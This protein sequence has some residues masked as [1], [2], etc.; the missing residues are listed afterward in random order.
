MSAASPR[1]RRRA[2]WLPASL[3]RARRLNTGT[4]ASRGQDE[5]EQMLL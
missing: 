4:V 2:Q 1:A 3:W 5:R